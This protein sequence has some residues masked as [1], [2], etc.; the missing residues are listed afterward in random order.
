[1]EK[2]NIIL[3][4]QSD[5]LVETNKKIAYQFDEITELNKLLVHD[6]DKLLYDIGILNHARLLA[7]NLSFADF[8][9]TFSDDKSAL[10]FI[11]GIKWHNGYQ[12]RKCQYKKFYRVEDGNVYKC[13]HCAHVESATVDT[14]FDNTKFSPVKALYLLYIIYTSKILNLKQVSEALNLRAATCYN[15]S[16]KVK[17]AMEL[18]KVNKQLKQDWTSLILTFIKTDIHLPER[19]GNLPAGNTSQ[20]T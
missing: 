19:S 18:N 20:F 8:T 10:Q 3:Q 13:R 14:L 5:T 6:K 17:L 12:C 16:R 11:A 2:A 4:A 9:K 7:E 1:L 15:F